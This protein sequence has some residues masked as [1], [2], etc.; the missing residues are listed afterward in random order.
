MAFSKLT[1]TF[2]QRQMFNFP[3]IDMNKLTSLMATFRNPGSC[4]F[5]YKKKSGFFQSLGLKLVYYIFEL[6][7]GNIS[8]FKGKNTIYMYQ[9]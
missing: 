6:P 9:I 3:N 5:V 4:Q 7:V 2:I 1:V 8:G